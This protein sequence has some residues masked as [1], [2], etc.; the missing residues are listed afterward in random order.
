[1]EHKDNSYIGFFEETDSSSISVS[2]PIH[3]IYFM[4]LQRLM[5]RVVFCQVQDGA[6]VRINHP[7][8]IIMSKNPSHSNKRNL[9]IT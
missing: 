5:E 8:L 4:L 3:H 6:S 1:M 2:K 7:L 9:L